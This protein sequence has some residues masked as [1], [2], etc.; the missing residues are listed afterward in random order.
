MI[1]RFEGSNG[2][3]LLIDVLRGFDLVEHD[4]SLAEKIANAGTLVVFAQDDI[5]MAQGDAENDVYFILTGDVDVVV[6]NRHIAI[7]KDGETV[8]E[9][10]LLSPSEPRSA[11]VS[12]RTSVVALKLREPDLR[13]F[14][15]EHQ[16]IWKSIAQTVAD[17]LRQ[18]SEMLS[19]PNLNPKLFI[20]CSAESLPIARAIQLGL[21]HDKITVQIWTD[22]VF[23]PSTIPIDGLLSIV[24]ETD[25][26]VFVFDE[27]D[28]VESRG[29]EFTAPRDN[30]IFELGLFM[31][32]L[33]RNRTFIV[34]GQSSDVK[35][36]TDLLGITPITYVEDESGKF[37]TV[38]GPVCTELREVIKKLGTR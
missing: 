13:Q 28:V 27:D 4:E 10:A 32:S 36:P 22:G 37:S 9:M 25:F 23:G 5:L 19:Q 15:D 6:N 21:K 26:A 35:I 24:R 38:M 29:A 2:K 34:K 12:A 17:R 16:H 20:G 1:D 3:R 18:R 33:E 31:G 11:T 7:R 8:G 30:T 14:A